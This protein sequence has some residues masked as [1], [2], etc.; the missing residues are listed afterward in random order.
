MSSQG[1]KWKEEAMTWANLQRIRQHW[2][3]TEKQKVVMEVTIYWPD[4][5]K[6]D[7]SN[8]LKI[9]EDSFTGILY[10]DDRWVL[11]RI[12]DFSVDKENP[13][14]E[15]RIYKFDEKNNG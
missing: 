9:L 2:I 8:I 3:P 15:V 5:R 6:R 10:D 11:S 14:C 13:R 7:C 1:K 12:M 4:H